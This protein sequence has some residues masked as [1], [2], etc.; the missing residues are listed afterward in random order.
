MALRLKHSVS[1]QGGIF[2]AR[3]PDEGRFHW[4]TRRSSKGGLGSW[5][6]G[7]E[8]R[9]RLARGAEVLNELIHRPEILA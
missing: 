4:T 7:N 2:R 1:G 9:R 6:G 8:R 5:S 3:P